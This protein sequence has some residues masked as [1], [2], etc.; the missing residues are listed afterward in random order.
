MKQHGILFPE[1][2]V[3]LLLDEKKKTLIRIFGQEDFII[4]YT[5]PK[6]NKGVNLNLYAGAIIAGLTSLTTAVLTNFPTCLLEA[7]RPSFSDM[8]CKCILRTKKD[9]KR[10]QHIAFNLIS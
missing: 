6:T 1:L 10:P 9:P 3:L 2:G 8:W 7:V 4:L 5:T